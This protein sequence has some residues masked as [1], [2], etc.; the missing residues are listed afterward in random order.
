MRSTPS[1]HEDGSVAAAVGSLPPEIGVRSTPGSHE[2]GRTCDTKA[3][4]QRDPNGQRALSLR[5]DDTRRGPEGES[6]T[7]SGRRVTV[8]LTI[9]RAVSRGIIKASMK[10]V[11]SEGN[12]HGKDDNDGGQ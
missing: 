8:P 2:Y 7:S 11:T 12:D 9:R 10:Y 3:S 5:L 4:P 6:T 1:P